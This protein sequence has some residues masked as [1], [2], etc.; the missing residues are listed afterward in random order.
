MAEY[1]IGID[2]HSRFIQVCLLLRKDEGFLR[3]ERDFATDWPVL[4]EAR[5]WCCDLLRVHGVHADPLRYVLESTSTYH[6]PVVRAFGGEPRIINPMLA[7]ASKRKTDV[8]DARMLA[9][10]AITGLWPPSFVPDDAIQVLRVLLGNRRNAQRRATQLSN[11]LNNIVLRF[12][13]TF[14]TLGKVM[15]SF[16]RAIL[17]DLASGKLPDAP[18]VCPQPLPEQVRGT[19]LQHIAE[20]DAQRQRVAE[21]TRQATRHAHNT[22]FVLGTGEIVSGKQLMPLLETVPGIGPLTALLW[23]AEIVAVHRFPSAKALAAFA[24]CDPSLKISAGKVAQHVRRGGNKTLHHAL[25][26]AAGQLIQKRNEPFGRWGYKLMRSHPKGGFRKACGAV[27]RRLATSLY[28]VQRTGESFSYDK[29]NFWRVPDVP[30]I[31]IQDMGL[32]R[33]TKI[34]SSLELHTSNQVVNAYM[35]TLASEKGVGEKCL[36]SIKQWLSQHTKGFTST[37]PSSDARVRKSAHR[38]KRASPTASSPTDA[39]SK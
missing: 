6:L 9:Y 21:L 30:S 8:L 13:H 19:L 15:G 31:P 34:L 37:G 11:R 1:G 14:G 4:N 39:S 20:Y 18:G 33:F 32:G 17:E 7:G 3:F 27:A 12:G 22:E 28:H 23:M 2:T 10:H 26:Q 25:M 36:A 35:T 38:L 5:Q 24:G 16:G 29:Y